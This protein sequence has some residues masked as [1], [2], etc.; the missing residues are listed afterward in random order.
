MIWRAKT[1][2]II[3]F[4]LTTVIWF[5]V[6]ITLT[7]VLIYRGAYVSYVARSPVLEQECDEIRPGMN[8]QQVLAITSKRTEPFDE[9]LTD[10][11]MFFSRKNA[12]CHV[13]L[14]PETSLVNRTYVQKNTPIAE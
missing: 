9:G 2:T 13:E 11:G 14:D 6:A 4:G 8:L 10:H 1:A 7:A 5:A 3:L 12:T